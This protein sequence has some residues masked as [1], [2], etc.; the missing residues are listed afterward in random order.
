MPGL[1]DD[2]PDETPKVEADKG[3]FGDIPDEAPS[4]LGEAALDV[5]KSGP[6][7]LAKGI[8][9][10]AGMSGDVREFN[11]NVVNWVSKALGHEVSPETASQVLRML[12]LM[13]GPTSEKLRSATE[14]VTG[15]FHEP[16]TM[17]GRFAET[18][19]EFVPAVIGG[20]GSTVSKLATRVAIPAIAGQTAAE[21]VEDPTI[22][23]YAKA[24]GALTAGLGAGA[25][26]AVRHAAQAETGAASTLGRAME[27]DADT[28]D[29]LLQRLAHARQ[30]RPEAT[31]ADVAGENTRGIVE[32]VAQTPGAGHQMVVPNLTTRQQGQMARMSDDLQTLLGDRRSAHQA[33]QETMAQR[34]QAADPLYRQALADGDVAVW[35]PELERLSSSP[36]VRAAMQGAVRTWRD[37]AIADSYGAM[38]PGAL[39]DR[40]GQ[41]SFLRGQ[42]PVFPNLQ[43]WDY[44]KRIIDNQIGAALRAG[45]NSKARTLTRLVQQLRGELDQQVPSYR[46]ARN[47]WEGP[48]NYLEAV[49]DGRGILSKAIGAEEM[50]ANFRNLSEAQQEAYRLG[51]ISAIRG[52]MGNDPA[53]MANMTKYL[54]SPEMREK[55]AAMMPTPEAAQAWRQALE[56]E[57]RSSELTGRALGNSATARRLALKEDAENLLGEVMSGAL[58]SGATTV[59]GATVGLLKRAFLVGPRKLRDKIM[60]RSDALLAELLTTP[61]EPEGLRG[62]MQPQSRPSVM[63]PMAGAAY[64][65][66]GP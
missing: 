58:I 5:A 52:K 46:A 66:P 63:S 10:M 39:V 20:P 49:E 60:S 62:A 64:T 15:K 26:Q 50:R 7:G 35:S 38:N 56:Y 44:T 16:Q 59:H 8:I 33:V 31:L 23:P 32:R 42:V 37:N 4:G 54:R 18:V 11:A 6:T 43:F 21:M 2:I 61:Q 24:A 12:P 3:L 65:N 13:Q 28:P 14:S 55:V 30:I 1:F 34:A 9:G 22:K 51:A 29:A 47:S 36:T 27:R 45:Q 25:V 41:L 40:G 57:I 17:A 48:S 53:A 19:G